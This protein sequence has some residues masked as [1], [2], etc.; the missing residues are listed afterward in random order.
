MNYLS[1]TYR[2]YT[3]VVAEIDPDDGTLS[4]RVEGLRGCITFV[5]E[6]GAGLIAEFHESVDQYIAWCEKRG[7]EPETPFSGKFLLRISPDL[8]VAVTLNAE[9]HG[10]ELNDYVEALIAADVAKAAAPA[11][12]KP[13]PA[14]AREKRAATAKSSTP[15]GRSRSG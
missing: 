10:T 3:G 15:S 7:V 9:R 8:H 6:T 2:G 14:V 13:M 1:M 12:P 11:K 5:S 4:G